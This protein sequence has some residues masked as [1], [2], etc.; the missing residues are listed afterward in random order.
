MDSPEWPQ[1]ASPDLP[2]WLPLPGKSVLAR[3]GRQPGQSRDVEKAWLELADHPVYGIM[4]QVL[5]L[6]ALDRELGDETLVLAPRLDRKVDDI[7]SETRV[8]YQ[9]RRKPGVAHK[10]DEDGFL[11]L[12]QIDEVFSQVANELRIQL[13]DLPFNTSSQGPWSR[14]LSLMT[15]AGLVVGLHDRWAVS[16][17]VLDRLHGGALMKQ[18]IRRG[19]QLREEIHDAFTLLWRD[20]IHAEE[21]WRTVA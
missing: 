17:H 12:G 20:G 14:V 21:D 19:Q 1:D 10:V 4:L 2:P 13:G 5:L 9:P 6:E 18:I 11:I 3:T 7:A 8:L 15:D 16:S